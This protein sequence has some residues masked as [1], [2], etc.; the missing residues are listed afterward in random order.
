[1]FHLTSRGA[2]FLIRDG[3][4]GEMKCVE[5][6][7]KTSFTNLN[8]RD[9]IY[10]ANVQIVEVEELLDKLSTKPALISKPASISKPISVL[11]S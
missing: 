8:P 9:F 11:N 5:R 6:G 2:K 1:M 4:S 10:D 3:K 7:K